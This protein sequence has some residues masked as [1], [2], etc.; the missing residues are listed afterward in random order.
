MN[1]QDI[2]KNLIN[3]ENMG[4]I[5]QK[6]YF[7]LHADVA[8]WPTKPTTEAADLEALG[9]LTGNITMKPGKRM[10]E[11]Y[12]T[13]DT[14]ELQM[15]TVGEKDGKSFVMHLRLF[16]PGLLEKILGFRNA[17]KNENM[18]FIVPDNNGQ[19]FLL[20]DAIRPATLE[21]DAEGAGTGK[22]TAARRGVGMEFTYK[23]SNILAYTGTVPLTIASSG[24]G[25]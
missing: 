2:N 16:H 21:S 17:T 19:M 6:L 20:G 3:G 7:G 10:F 4:G 11:M 12:I 25:V 13:D 23:T 9:A 24:S 1:F 18:V 15:E 5:A 8:T 14:G 22:E